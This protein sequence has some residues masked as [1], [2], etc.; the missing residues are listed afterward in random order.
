MERRHFLNASVAGAAAYAAFRGDARAQGTSR[1]PKLKIREVRAVRLRGTVTNYVR[2]YTDQGLTGTGEMVDNVGADVI[3]NKNLGPGL[4]GKDPLD[5]EGIWFNYWGWGSPPGGISPVFMRGMGGPYLTA[6]SGIDIA[7][8]DL[9]G[10]ALGVPVYRLFGGLVR[11]RVAVY[12]HSSDPAQA[13]EIIR[14]TGVRALKT[15][16]D[17]VTDKDNSQAGWDPG[18]RFTWVVNNTQIDNIARQIASMREAVGNDFGLALECH[19]RY[20]T[21]SAIQIAK[22]VEPYRP[23]W[24]E[25]PVP[26]DNPEAMA[27]VRSMTRIPIAAGENIYTRWGLQPYVERQALSVIQMDMSKCGGLLESRKMAALAEVY[28]IPIAPHGVAS[29]LGKV[30]FAHVCATV[31]NFM[32]LEWALNRT[33]N[34]PFTTAATLEKGFCVLPQAPGIGI[35]LHDDAVKEALEPGSQA[36]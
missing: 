5:I 19:A 4:V 22:A 29:T 12:H 10:K 1:V 21:E 35:E 20:D 36:L 17:G 24:L 25:E 13:K 2:V 9:A 6:M 11:D 31:P 3:V 28:H 26:S 23:M 16:V 14:T 33:V 7:L 18:K 15:T 32:I 27:K 34:D 8:W 30:A